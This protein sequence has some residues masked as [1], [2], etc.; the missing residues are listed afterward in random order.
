MAKGIK[1]ALEAAK[2]ASKK[3]SEVYGEHEGK[4][5]FIT[6]ADRTKVGEGFLGGPGF[7]GIQLTNPMYEGAGWG[8]ATKGKGKTLVAPLK[9]MDPEKAIFSTYIGD[10]YQHRSN[11]MVFDKLLGT[12]Q[13][14]ARKGNLDPE[15]KEI[16]NQRLRSAV[17][18]EGQALFPENVDITS[19]KF[20]NLANTFDKR[21]LAASVMGGEGVGGR[22]GRIIDYESIIQSAT[23]PMLVD[24]PTGSVGPR[25]FT[26][27]GELVDRPDLHPAF[28]VI[29]KGYDLGV[30]YAPVPRELLMRDYI[31]RM[32]KEKGRAP[33][34]FD[35]S[36]GYPKSQLI[37]EDL[38]TQMQKAG[39]KS[40]GHVK[41]PLSA[42][43][44]VRKPKH[45]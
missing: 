32:M 35:Y 39:Y 13:S 17:N 14:Q 30:E 12:F 11:Q 15:L 23:D 33:G 26:L 45:G 22:K 6:E 5:L 2:K 38:L 29:A 18:K 37:T 19:R 36:R 4:P 25:L 28:P 16:V 27:T 8:V 20:R 10:P 1:G 9:E 3:A 21:A 24:V 43:S 41:S 42:L 31:D 7:S 44:K 40:G 34:V